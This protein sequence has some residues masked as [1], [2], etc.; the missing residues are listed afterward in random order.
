MAP[1]FVRNEGV[2]ALV[3]V[4]FLATHRTSEPAGRSLRA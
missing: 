4:I 1:V 2:V 3:A